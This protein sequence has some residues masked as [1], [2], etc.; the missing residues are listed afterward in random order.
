M[1]VNLVVFQVPSRS[2]PAAEKAE[3]DRLGDA[4]KLRVVHL[5]LKGSPPKM[6]FLKSLFPLIAAAG[7]NAVL[8]EYEDM[9]PFEGALR[10]ASARNAY[11][12]EEVR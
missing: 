3:V 9:F 12:R 4:A 8:V 10:N 7:A 5:D 2:K 11:S 1:T 6:H